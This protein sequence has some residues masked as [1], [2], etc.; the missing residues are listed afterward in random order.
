MKMADWC[1]YYANRDNPEEALRNGS[2]I[3]VSRHGIAKFV[4]GDFQGF[5]DDLPLA[6]LTFVERERAKELLPPHLN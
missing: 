5:L 2:F 4:L 6:L 3:R 1:E